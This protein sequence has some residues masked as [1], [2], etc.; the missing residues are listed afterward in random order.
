MTDLTVSITKNIS[1]PIEKV[2]DAWLDPSMLTQFILPAPGMPQP[3]VE[4][5]AREG[6]RF[7]IVM[8]VGENKIPHFGT[9]LIIKRPQHLVF[10]WESPFSVDG[11]QVDIKFRAIDDQTTQVDLTHSKFADEESRDNHRGGWSVILDTLDEIL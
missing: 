10:S 7:T 11:S 3:D 2:F 9:Y 4:N 1:A 8:Q 5:D 6:G